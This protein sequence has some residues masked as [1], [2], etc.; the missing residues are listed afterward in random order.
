MVPK[1]Q[2]PLHYRFYVDKC[3]RDRE[4]DKKKVKGRLLQDLEEG[5][6]DEPTPEEEAAF[7]TTNRDGIFL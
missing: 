6:T 3:N 7:N 4:N 2:N 1:G 5:Y